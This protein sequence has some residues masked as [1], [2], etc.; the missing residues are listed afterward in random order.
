MSAAATSNLEFA[1]TLATKSGE[2]TT[3]MSQHSAQRV[4]NDVWTNN[5]KI[6]LKVAARALVSQS[7]MKKFT[8]ILNE[9]LSNIATQF[10]VLKEKKLVFSSLSAGD[11]AQVYESIMMAWAVDE[12]LVGEDQS[13]KWLLI[14]QQIYTSKPVYIG[15]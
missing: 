14:M 4:I 7:F 10:E 13:D 15:P 1:V 3:L 8:P 11:C 9:H 2:L 5:R 6:R 12:Q